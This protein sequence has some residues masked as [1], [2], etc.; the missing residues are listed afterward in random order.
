MGTPECELEFKYFTKGRVIE[1]A[2]HARAGRWLDNLLADSIFSGDE[3]RALCLAI[4][5][6]RF[7]SGTALKAQCV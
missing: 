7:L 1:G 2:A 3:T 4:W 6:A 5:P